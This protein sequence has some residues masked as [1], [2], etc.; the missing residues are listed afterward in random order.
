MAT[1]RIGTVQHNERLVMFAGR[2]HRF[3]HAPNVGV[4]P[5]AN[6]L[7]VVKQHIDLIQQYPWR[8]L[9]VGTVQRVYP[10]ARLTV[11]RFVDGFASWDNAADT[12]LRR[13]K[14]RQVYGVMSVQ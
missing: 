3:R 6:I 11:D 13:K 2:R 1:K 4:C 12:V 10:Q 9:V 7:D 14:Q 8:S 5:A